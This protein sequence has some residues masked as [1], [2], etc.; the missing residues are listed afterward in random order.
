MTTTLAI[1]AMLLCGRLHIAN[2]TGSS[3]TSSFVKAPRSFHVPRY[4]ALVL[5]NV[6]LHK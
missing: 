3:N 1:A 5:D 2:R 6:A 4:S